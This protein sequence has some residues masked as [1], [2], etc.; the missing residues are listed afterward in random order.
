MPT[1]QKKLSTFLESGMHGAFLYVTAHQARKDRYH[2]FQLMG[3]MIE[4][5]HHG[6]P[7][8]VKPDGYYI[9]ISHT[10]N[11]QVILLS[12]CLCGIDIESSER[13]LSPQM[14]RTLGRQCEMQAVDCWTEIEA[15]CKMTQRSL[16]QLAR[17]RDCIWSDDLYKWSLRSQ[18]FIGSILMARD[19]QDIMLANGIDGDIDVRKSR[20]IHPHIN[21]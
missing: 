20:L 7:H 18:Y 17:N 14:L 6:R 13:V 9:S 12:G 3:V 19:I 4:H 10:A 5:D 11:T 16:F 21:R 15:Y 1:M 8:V 2:Q